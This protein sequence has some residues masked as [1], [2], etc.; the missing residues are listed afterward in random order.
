MAIRK[1]RGVSSTFTGGTGVWSGAS[2]TGYTT[3]RPVLRVP[4]GVGGF[5]QP[6][7]SLA[8]SWNA[9]PNSVPPISGPPAP[10]PPPTADEKQAAATSFL[11]P[12][13]TA[14][15]QFNASSRDNIYS[16]LT[17]SA[18]YAQADYGY[19]GS[20]T[21]GDGIP[22]SGFTLDPNNPF[23]RAAL[24]QKTYEQNQRGTTNSMAAQGQLYSGALQDAQ[25]ENTFQNQAGVDS[26]QKSFNR[27]LDELLRGRRDAG[28]STERANADVDWQALVAAVAARGGG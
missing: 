28:L 18:G 21:N 3:Q 8:P 17:K 10:A 26:N 14:A 5:N 11:N 20:D 2:S 16:D 7:P 12:G 23:S 15:K 24:L 6:S 22:D 27:M 4:G 19:T 13:A 25:N 9:A 1:K